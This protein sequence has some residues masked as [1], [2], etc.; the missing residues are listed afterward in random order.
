M[1]ENK[2]LKT[3]NKEKGMSMLATKFKKFFQAYE[4]E[5]LG[6]PYYIDADC[7]L[8]ALP[9]EDIWVFRKNLDNSRVVRANN[10]ED[11]LSSLKALGGAAVGLALL[12]GLLLPSAYNL[13]AGYRIHQLRQEKQN[14]ATENASLESE[15]A[16]LLSPHE[17]AKTAKKQSFQPAPDR[18]V[19]LNPNLNASFAMNLKSQK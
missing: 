4:S 7:Q 11:N 3:A 19:L 18:I 16:Q 15:R 9:M 1:S 17:L 14:L 8:R 10:P 2:P 13:M 6:S 12:I 5:G